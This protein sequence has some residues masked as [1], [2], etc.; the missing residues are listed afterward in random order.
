MSKQQTIDNS[1]SA[2][3]RSFANMSSI[4][5]NESID[6]QRENNDSRMGTVTNLPQNLD[7][8]KQVYYSKMQALTAKLENEK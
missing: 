6:Y 3:T 4:R 2:H 7:N 8:I 5:G 1:Q